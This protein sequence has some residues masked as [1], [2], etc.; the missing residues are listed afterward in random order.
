MPSS[1]D[2]SDRLQDLLARAAAD[3]VGELL[4]EAREA[5]RDDVREILR[6]RW[7]DAYL[8]A[9]TDPPSAPADT[10]SAWW[11]YCAVGAGDAA[12]VPAGLEGVAAA[13]AVE[14]VR[15]GD[16]AAVV[17][18]VPLAEFGD[19][20]LRRHL[21]DLAWVERVARAHE[22]V[23]EAVMASVTI[24]PLRLCTL[25]LTRERVEALL[26][27]Q[28]AE[29]EPALE[30]LRGRAEWGIKVFATSRAAAAEREDEAGTARSEAGAYLERKRRDRA[31]RERAQQEAHDCVQGVHERL[32]QESVAVAVNPPQQPEAH[33][34]DAEMLLNAAYLVDDERRDAL[35]SAVDE[36]AAEHAAAGFAV[37]LTGPWPP[38]NFVSPATSTMP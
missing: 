13:T 3:D 8:R 9:V 29:L 31:A 38:Y 27:E 10:G 35:H 36:L 2:D 28:A 22:A 15:S 12:L 20:P 16:L 33:G 21:E 30:A 37:E 1:A 14:V 4:A 26:A 18:A 32:A 11:V 7:R 19:E 5:A 24:V 23:L 17:S 34:R 6:E 25:C